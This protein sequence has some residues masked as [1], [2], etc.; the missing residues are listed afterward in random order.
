MNKII[1]STIILTRICLYIAWNSSFFQN[2]KIDGWHHMYTGVVLMIVSAIL[3]KKSSKL[4]FGIGI[5]LF[6]D[7]LI[8]LFHILGITTATDYWSFKSI[9]TTLLG[10]SLVLV[11]DYMS[12]RESTKSI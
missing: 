3:P 12:K 1:L 11:I 2:Q 4:F 10:L 9:V 6:I 8:H 5:G 7:E